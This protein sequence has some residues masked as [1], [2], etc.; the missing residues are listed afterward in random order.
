VIK[1]V[2]R[3]WSSFKLKLNVI[4]VSNSLDNFFYEGNSFYFVILELYL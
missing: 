2:M 3:L 4:I 1:E